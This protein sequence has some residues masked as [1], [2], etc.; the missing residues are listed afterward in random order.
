M[1]ASYLLEPQVK[2]NS[3]FHK[4]LLVTES[5][6]SGRKVSITPH[7]PCSIFSRGYV[8][9]LHQGKESRVG[10][11]YPPSSRTTLLPHSVCPAMCISSQ[12]PKVLLST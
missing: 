2:A 11:G 4:L 10:T 8:A 12:L 3:F 6:Y 1:M 5:Y 7:S 9:H